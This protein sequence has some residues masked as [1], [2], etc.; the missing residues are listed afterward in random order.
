MYTLQSAAPAINGG[1]YLRRGMAEN[2]LTRETL[3][4]PSGTNR[5]ANT[6]FV[7]C[8]SRRLVAQSSAFF[9]RG[10]RDQRSNCLFSPR[11][12]SS[13]VSRS[14]ATMPAK[15]A[16]RTPASSRCPLAANAPP[17]MMVVSAGST[18]KSPSSMA[19]TKMIR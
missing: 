6:T 5:P 9:V 7:P 12:V 8:F 3:V 17:V 16:P 2:P 14:P 1:R 13:W 18:G 19:I 4:R 11:L 10:R 15:V